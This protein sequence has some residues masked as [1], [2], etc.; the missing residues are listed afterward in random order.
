MKKN[1]P[2]LDVSSLPGYAFG[3]RTLMWW[4]T[5]GMILTEGAIFAMLI[6]AY[7]YLR[8][9]TPDWP[10]NAM[11]PM[12]RWGVA[13]TVVL[14]LSALP[15]IWYKRAAEREDLKK[16]RIGLVIGVIFAI[17]FVV[18]RFFEFG[19][20]NT[21]YDTNAYGSVVW[22]L[23]GF[24]TTHLITD[25]ID[26]VVLTALMFTGPIEGKRFSDVSDNAFYWYFVVIA[27]LPIFAVIY[28]VPRW[29]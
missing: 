26:T 6:A 5:L 12:L 11:P 10:P 18:I 25:L 29:W 4:G 13:N 27:W 1:T 2:A 23:L 8:G 15:N 22:T 7:F 9:R 14:L 24:H 16:V 17:A 28:L 3:P 20:L 21:R 19:A